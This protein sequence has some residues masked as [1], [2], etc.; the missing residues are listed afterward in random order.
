ML[1]TAGPLYAQCAERLTEQIRADGLPSG[2]HLPSE[3]V[4]AEAL[5][6]TRLTVRRALAMIETLVDSDELGNTAATCRKAG[7]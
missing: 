7:T 6:F 1:E 2:A 3:R 5:G 4:L